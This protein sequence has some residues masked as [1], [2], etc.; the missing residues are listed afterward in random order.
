LVG[1]AAPALAGPTLDG[2]DF[3]LAEHRGEWVLVNFFATWCGPCRREHD[4]LA[5]FHDR[6]AELG[7]ASVV[8]VVYDDTTDDAREFFEERGGNWPVVIGDQGDLALDYGVIKVPESYLVSPDGI[9]VKK[10]IGGVTQE[11]LE[12]L[13]AAAEQQQPG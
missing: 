3:D 6:H 8:S 1:R 5:R 11:F 2:S 10:L 7:D 12:E 4:E 9:V 13:L